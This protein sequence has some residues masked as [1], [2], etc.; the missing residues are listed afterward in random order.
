MNSEAKR[1]LLCQNA[2]CSKA[3]P[4]HTD[5]PTCMRLY[6]EG[7]YVEAGKILFE[8]NPLSALTSIV[9]DWDRFCYGN[10]ILNAKKEPVAWYEIEQE[11]SQ[12]FLKE[13]HPSKPKSNGHT[14]GII[15]SGP[16]GMVSAIKLAALG[17][18]V[19]LYDRQKQMGGL[20]RYG[21]P[22]FRLDKK[23][24]DEIERVVL[25]YGIHFIG[26]IKVGKDISLKDIRSKYEVT[27]IAIGAFK[28]RELKI[29]G[30]EMEHVLR[31]YDYLLAPEQ[32]QLGE[33]VI[34]IG[35]GNVAMDAARTAKRARKE[36][37][38]FYRKTFENMPA[39]V[40]EIEETKNEGV[41]FTT[42]VAPV[43]VKEK[44]VVF[45]K[46]ENVIQEDGRVVT[47][48]LEGTDFE[49]PCDSLLIAAGEIVD[50]QIFDEKPE[51]DEWGWPITD[52]YG[53]TSFEDVYLTGDFL[54]GAS[55]IV[56]AVQNAKKTV[57]GIDAYLRG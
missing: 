4:V 54:R 42:F 30:E 27:I 14:V 32:Y 18:E 37:S 29:P 22:A 25:E 35:G 7:K 41:S 36:V 40:R 53:K 33:K 43:K 47:K 6:R 51:M 34:V 45:R 26:N 31:A 2:K 46:C 9:C 21:I 55:T 56:Q 52:A 8:N 1:C 28:S 13:Y 20:L 10:C 39:N 12:N 49:V 23:V 5:V 48:I 44:A 50:Y 15:G 11:L 17:Y 16:S 3:C 24:V 38:I 57:Q 19:T